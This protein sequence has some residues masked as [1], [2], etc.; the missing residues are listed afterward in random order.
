MRID[1]LARHPADGVRRIADPIVFAVATQLITHAIWNAFALPEAGRSIVIE[2]ACSAFAVSRV[3]A[4]ARL[5][6]LYRATAD[7][8]VSCP[9]APSEPRYERWTI[10]GAASSTDAGGGPSLTVLK[11]D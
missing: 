8:D 1:A 2:F 4:I 10:A 11:A 5:A 6:R 9:V 3:A 7:V